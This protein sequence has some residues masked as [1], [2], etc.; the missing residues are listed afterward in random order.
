MSVGNCIKML[1]ANSISAFPIKSNPVFNN[2]LKSL[3]KHPPDCTIL[4]NWVFDSY[5]LTEE[6]FVKA[7]QS[8]ETWLLGNNN[9]FGKFFWLLESPT[10]FDERF[11]VTSVLFFI[12]DF[13]LLR[14][15]LDNCTFNTLYW[16]IFYI[17][18]KYKI[19]IFLQFL[20][21]N[22]NLFL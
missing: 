21:K 2:G 7:L 5:I 13:N 16:V 18:A 22:L 12:A 19:R 15:E 9:L 17:K 4:W 3:P 1:L 8:L 14:Y 20:V 6:L 10:T 11:K